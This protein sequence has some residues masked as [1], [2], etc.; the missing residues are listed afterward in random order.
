MRSTAIKY[1]IFALLLATLGAVY[2]FANIARCA[3]IDFS[4]FNEIAKNV[5]VSGK[6]PES[7]HRD[8]MTLLGEAKLR[9]TQHY[10][11][12]R[13][14]PVIIVVGN[15]REAIDYGLYGA[16]GKLFYTPWNNYLVLNYEKK[17]VDVAAHELV[18]AEIVSRLG[19][20]RRQRAIPTWF[21]EGAAMQVDFRPKYSVNP[22][23]FDKS[24]IQRVMK[25][26]SRAKFWSSNKAQNIKN[27]QAAKAAVAM[28]LKG[29]PSES[30]Y[31]L[32]AEIKKGK[33]LD[34]FFRKN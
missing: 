21:D 13:A 23:S 32:L 28:F 18:H 16:P 26:N 29:H 34:A 4:G 24:E 10:G 25:L 12:P 17:S 27:Y 19:Y 3:L 9:I 15:D 33:N 6:L 22:G 7:S 20:F 11:A 14:N 2:G 30:L 1:V 5:Y 8:V 31:V